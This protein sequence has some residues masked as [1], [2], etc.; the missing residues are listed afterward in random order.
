LLLKT[1]STSSGLPNSFQVKE[2]ECSFEK[3][4]RC[5]DLKAKEA[6]KCHMD[7]KL[8]AKVHDFQIGDRVYVKSA[9]GNKSTPRYD[10]ETYSISKIKGSMIEAQRNG[11]IIVRNCSFF[12]KHHLHVELEDKLK[13][14]PIINLSPVK[15]PSLSKISNSN[16]NTVSDRLIRL[17]VDT[18][19]EIFDQID[20]SSQLSI[21]SE[22]SSQIEI[23]DRVDTSSP[24]DL[25]PI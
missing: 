15:T 19:S 13:P 17:D 5:N 14:I 20:K 23:F 7:K 6:M 10:P 12:R 16:I 9:R 22:N 8:K 3:L 21:N 1:Q 24:I 11:K 4:A 25:I 2:T 18:N